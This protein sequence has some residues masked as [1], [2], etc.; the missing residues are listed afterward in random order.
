MIDYSRLP[1]NLREGM[2]RYIEEG[3]PTGDFLRACLSNDLMDAMGRASTKTFDYVHSVLM[4]LYNDV[5][6]WTRDGRPWGS[7]E[8][9]K[10]WI[11]HK[12]LKGL[13]VTHGK[14]VGVRGVQDRGVE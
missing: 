13:E 9:V 12:G 5:P 14:P 11:E 4:F 10:R 8:A 6:I 1:D 3:V 2:Q 7:K